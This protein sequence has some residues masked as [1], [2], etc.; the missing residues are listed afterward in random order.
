M[1]VN[2]KFETMLRISQASTVLA[3]SEQ[4]FSENIEICKK[5]ENKTRS[6]LTYN[7]GPADKPSFKRS[8]IHHLL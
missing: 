7:N 1:F 4:V 2:I 5:G 3:K 8:I 6:H